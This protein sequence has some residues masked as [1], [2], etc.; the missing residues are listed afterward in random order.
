MKKQEDHSLKSFSIQKRFGKGTRTR[1]REDNLT[2]LQK[3]LRG[4]IAGHPYLIIVHSPFP[5]PAQRETMYI[6]GEELPYTLSG[7]GVGK[8]ALLEAFVAVAKAVKEVYVM[9]FLD[10]REKLTDGDNFFKDFFAEEIL[11]RQRSLKNTP[12]FW[13]LESGFRRIGLLMRTSVLMS[14]TFLAWLL[15]A[16]GLEILKYFYDPQIHSGVNNLLRILSQYR[17]WIWIVGP[18]LL[19]GWLLYFVGELEVKKELRTTY[20]A[21]SPTSLKEAH[22]NG[23]K[24][25]LLANPVN[26]FSFLSRRKCLVLVVDDVDYLDSRSFD[27]IIDLFEAV[28]NSNGKYRAC[29]VLSFNPRNPALWL[30]ERERIRELLSEDSIKACQSWLP[31]CITPLDLEQL[32]EILCEYFGDSSP[33]RLLRIIEREEPEA[34]RRTGQLLG[35]F[36]WLETVLAKEQKSLREVQESELITEFHRYVYRDVSGPLAK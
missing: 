12:V 24:E 32:A 34:L 33:E 2:Y 10:N 6:I 11:K 29:V 27:S 35:F 13:A 21:L 31:I 8:T 36:V 25:R 1:S 26:V 22:R 9:A 3:T 5:E 23:Q 30:P 16:L 19:I 20:S 28:Q 14:G 15:S 17:G 7:R 4:A 18:L